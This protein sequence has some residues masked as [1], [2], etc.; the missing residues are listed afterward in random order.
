MTARSVSRERPL[1]FLD[2]DG[3]LIPFGGP[4]SSHPARLV[5][6]LPAG[7]AAH[8]LLSR[9]DPAHGARLSALPC[10]PVWATTWMADANDYLAPLLGLPPLDVVVWPEPSAVDERDGRRGLHWKT[11]TIVSWATG[12]SFVWVDDEITPA[13]RSWVS[14]H[15]PGRALLHRVDPTRGLT[16][17]DYAVLHD[18]LRRNTAPPAQP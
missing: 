5:A 17:A 7:L 16:P 18:W 9:L 12:R 1:L 14:A 15:H 11:R 2:V 13:D 8:L 6:R 3:P 10:T 4:P